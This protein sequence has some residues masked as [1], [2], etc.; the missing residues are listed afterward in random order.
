MIARPSPPQP[1]EAPY[2][3]P[4]LSQKF[5][6]NTVIEGTVREDHNRLRIT[7][8]VLGSDGFQMSSHRFD[9]EATAEVLDQVQQQIATAIVSRARPELSLV[10][11]RKA[12]PSA[13]MLAAYAFVQHAETLLDEGS[14]YDL[15]AALKKFQEARELA[16][17]FARSYCGISH[18]NTEIALRGAGP[19][20]TAGLPCEGSC[21]AR[22]RTGCRDD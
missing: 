7:A 1:V 18:C 3:I 19:S 11:R 16:P 14:A 8:R 12:A 21:P 15:P 13:L 6:L 20:S 2:D 5:G 17:A 4:S 10:R 9:T 22:D